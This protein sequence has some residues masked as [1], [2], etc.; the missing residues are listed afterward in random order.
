ML[1]KLF[2]LTPI[3]AIVNILRIARERER[4]QRQYTVIEGDVEYSRP[5]TAKEGDG[6]KRTVK[7]GVVYLESE[8][9]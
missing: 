5:M 7:C 4:A 8:D 3:G 6:W 2:A 9:E 1:K